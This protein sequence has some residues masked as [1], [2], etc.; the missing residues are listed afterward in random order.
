MPL[1]ESG[2][3]IFGKDDHIVVCLSPFGD[4]NRKPILALLTLSEE[5]PPKFTCSYW[6]PENVGRSFQSLCDHVPFGQ[7]PKNCSV[8]EILLSEQDIM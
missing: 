7:I 1:V 2:R 8:L 4:K 5:D 6:D 3:F